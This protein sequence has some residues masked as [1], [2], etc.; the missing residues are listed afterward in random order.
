MGPFQQPAKGY[1]TAVNRLPIIDGTYRTD[2]NAAGCLARHFPTLAFYPREFLI[3]FRAAVKAKRGRYDYAEWCRSSLD[4][5][6]AL[7]RSGVRLEITGLQ[8]VEALKG[9]CVFIGNHMSTLETFTLPGTLV[10]IRP[11]TFV[12]KQS[13]VDYPIFGHVM[14][15]RDPITVGRTNPREDLKAVL[16]GGTDRLARGI[17]IVI[18]PQTTRRAFFDPAEFN[19][20]GV[21]LAKRAG[22]PIIPIALKTDAW[23]NGTL[24]KD[25]GPIDP[26]RTAHFAFGPPLTVAGRGEAEHEEIVRFITHHLIIWGGSVQGAPAAA[27]A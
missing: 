11:V 12:V 9:P 3:V 10:P 20:I 18:F 21:K 4:T 15:S 17:S 13:L 6:R 2:D 19:S 22:V 25:Y 1:A 7:E 24:A 23:S 8:H 27:D 5:I 16:E 14:R 26:S